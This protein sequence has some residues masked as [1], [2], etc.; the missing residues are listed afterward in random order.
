MSSLGCISMNF[1]EMLPNSNGKDTIFVIADKL[2]K[3]AHFLALSHPY[4]AKIVVE[5]FIEGVAK[6]NGVLQTIV[7][8][9]DRIFTSHF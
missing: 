2:S 5:K 1:I 9:R 6:L 7:S 4:I 3:S 8:D